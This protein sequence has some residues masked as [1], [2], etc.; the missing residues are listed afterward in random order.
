M[1]RCLTLIKKLL[2]FRIPQMKT[3]WEHLYLIVVG[4]SD[5]KNVSIESQDQLIMA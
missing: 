5:K 1:L 3:V 2:T 4:F